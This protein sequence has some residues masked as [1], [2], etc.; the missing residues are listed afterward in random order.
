MD[1][2]AAEEEQLAPL[3][4][5]MERLRAEV[6]ELQGRWEALGEE[7]EA[8]RRSL[9][10]A[11]ATVELLQRRHH[12]SARSEVEGGDGMLRPE[13]EDYASQTAQVNM[14]SR[15]KAQPH[16][17]LSISSRDLTFSLNRLLLAR[18]LAASVRPN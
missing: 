14:G 10:L 5:L 1:Q 7:L 4:R 13:D 3:M 6:T 17:T 11:E 8:K 18:R 15:G 12:E 9:R 16:L 2:H